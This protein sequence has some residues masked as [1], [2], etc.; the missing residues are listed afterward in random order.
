VE[1][2]DDLERRVLK[3]TKGRNVSIDWDAVRTAGIQRLG[4]PVPVTR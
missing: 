4:Y 3:A 2:P 1:V